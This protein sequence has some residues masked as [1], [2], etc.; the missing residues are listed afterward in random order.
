MRTSLHLPSPPRFTPLLSQH[1][2]Q[3]EGLHTSA[4]T[5]TRLH[6]PASITPTRPCARDL[7]GT[8]H[9]ND[10]LPQQCW[11]LYKRISLITFRSSSMFKFNFLTHSHLLSHPFTSRYFDELKQLSHP[12]FNSFNIN[13]HSHGTPIHT[14]S[15][16]KHTHSTLFHTQSTESHQ[17]NTYSYPFNT[18]SRNHTHSTRFHTLQQVFKPIQRNHT[19]STRIHTHPHPP[20]GTLRSSSS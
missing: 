6:T 1:W 15:T 19:H 5:P 12:L 2:G 14:H 8:S 11:K 13:A 18:E 4:L 16:R 9:P 3:F 20:S 17:F 7:G 10:H